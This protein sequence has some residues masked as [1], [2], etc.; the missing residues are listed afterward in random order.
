[1]KISFDSNSGLKV[2]E[3]LFDLIPNAELNLETLKS[4]PQRNV[5]FGARLI[6]PDKAHENTATYFPC[7]LW[8]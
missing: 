8:P 5:L 2:Q 1:M 7:I 4:V 3:S 6:R